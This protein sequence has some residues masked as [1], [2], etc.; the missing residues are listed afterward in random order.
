[1]ETIYRTAILITVSVLSLYIH[2]LLVNVG[3]FYLTPTSE[4]QMGTSVM[5][6]SSMT[7]RSWA[8]AICSTVFSYLTIGLIFTFRKNIEILNSNEEKF[9]HAWK[10]IHAIQFS[11]MPRLRVKYTISKTIE[12]SPLILFALALSFATTVLTS[13]ALATINPFRK[14]GENRVVSTS[15]GVPNPKLC[16]SIL[17]KMDGRKFKYFEKFGLRS[18]VLV[19]GHTYPIPCPIRCHKSMADEALRDFARHA[20]R[21][22]IRSLATLGRVRELT[23]SVRILLTKLLWPRDK[24]AK[25]WLEYALTRG[26][27]SVFVA[28]FVEERIK[29]V[30]RSVVPFSGLIFGLFELSLR[31]EISI[32][33][34]P[35][36]LFHI[37]SDFMSCGFA[38]VMHCI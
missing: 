27:Y 32:G 2:I 11:R 5:M 29:E 35:P 15:L 37:F 12:Y 3:Q 28:P 31:R 38:I 25:L 8:F 18:V 13:F 30:L 26:L 16:D 24:P 21:E 1:M 14:K 7:W 36:L 6:L 17:K 23:L 33:S 34:L 22:D 20:S 10:R 9:H 4:I 19:D